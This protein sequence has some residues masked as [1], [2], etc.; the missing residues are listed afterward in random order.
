MPRRR[1]KRAVPSL[2]AHGAITLA[3]VAVLVVIMGI[4]LFCHRG[5]GS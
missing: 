5:G 4:V 2:L 3:S 1:R